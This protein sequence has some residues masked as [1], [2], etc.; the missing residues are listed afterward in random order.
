VSVTG[1]SL[2][3]SP[4]SGRIVG[5]DVQHLVVWYWCLKAAV[6]GSDI[7]SVEVEVD[8][9]GNLD[10]VRVTYSDG[11]QAYWQVKATV[12][13]GS[14]ANIAWLMKAERA[15]SLIQR[16]Y[17]SWVDLRRPDGGVALIT[18]RPLDHADPLLRELGRLD[19]L[20]AR[21]RRSTEPKVVEARATLADHIGCDVE[22]L[23]D[24]LDVLEIHVGQTEGHWRGKVEDVSLAAGVRTGDESRSLGLTEV[25]EWVKTTRSAR[26]RDEL[27]GR[28]RDLGIL[29]E[30]PRTVL[31]VEALDHVPDA[32]PED[33]R[34]D[35]VHQFRG[36]TPQ[37]RRGVVE[38]DAWNNKLAGDLTA[39]REHLLG[40]GHRS[41]V[42]RGA[43]RLPT[44]FAVG[45]A[46]SDVAGFDIAAMD[47]GR[48]WLPGQPTARAEVVVQSD[49]PTEGADDHVA[50]V[51]QV[52]QEGFDDV[53]ESLGNQ[54]GRI[55]ALTVP[56]GP[57]RRLFTDGTDA[58]AA[59]VAIRDWVRRNLKG[60]DIHMV[61]LANGPFALFLGHLWDRVPP[62]TLYEDLAPGY[63]AAFHFRNS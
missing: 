61:L 57:D 39:V 37:T 28:V 43:M 62:T 18:G 60:V 52:S 27:I 7:D 29:S 1:A 2:P 48:L 34:L 46:L 4:S 11:R 38:A 36:E 20:G 32:D 44:W 30:E 55:V 23:C 31:V 12:S 5:D 8:G 54:A 35:W 56:G 19:R 16:L 3:P 9:V 49:V 6:P 22:Q 25:R 53:R 10:D 15:G 41:V 21:V 59:A 14:V 40:T 24:F 47:R 51:V 42:V 17:Q 63:E 50:L 45:H 26:T 33:L 13:A 58:F